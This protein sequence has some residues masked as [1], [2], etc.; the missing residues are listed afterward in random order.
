MF[1]PE[2]ITGIAPSDKVLDIGPGAHPHPRAD[3]LLELRYDDPKE[4]FKQLGHDQPLVTDKQVVY[5]D[6]GTFPFG[7]LE[8]D[9]VI[10]SHVLEHV[11]DV[12]A[13]LAEVFRVGRRGYFEYPLA[14]YDLIYNIDAH[15]NFL[16][17]RP[18]GLHHM[19]KSSTGLDRFKPLQSLMR[20]TLAHGHTQLVDQLVDLFIEGFE[21]ERPFATI[22]CDHLEDIC[23]QAPRIPDPGGFDLTS[24]GGRKLVQ[25][26]FTVLKQKVGI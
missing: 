26:L 16:K 1:F 22:A 11:P 8:F 25:A 6:G 10:C 9:Y 17:L 21:W 20:E 3:V 4:Y 24:V 13:F 15:L 12:P 14:Y 18:E 7:E 5:Y 19:K 23:H 2:R